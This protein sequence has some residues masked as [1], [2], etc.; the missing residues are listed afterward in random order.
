MNK[1]KK[2]MP[3]LM[4][5]A[6]LL[7][8]DSQPVSLSVGALTC[9]YAVQPLGI[10]SGKPSLGWQIHSDARNVMQASFRVL[11]SDN[12]E[13]LA[14]DEG[15]CWDSGKIRSDVSIQ[16]F[17]DGLPLRPGATYFWKVKIW[18]AKG[19][20]SPWS[21]MSSWQMGLPDKAAWGGAKWIALEELPA[22]KRI[23][24]GAENKLHEDLGK[25]E[26]LLPFLRKEFILQDKALK[27]ATAFVSGLGHFDM[28]I[29]GEKVG[30]HF[31][32]PGWTEYDHYALYL[33]FDILP[34]LRNGANACGL[35]LGNG[36]FHTPHERYLK[37]VVSY[38]YPKAICKLQIEYEDGTTEEII[39]DT[40]WKAAPSPVTFSS[41]Y[42]GED[43]D[44]RLEQT[45]WNMPGFDDS[46]WQQALTVSGTELRSQS[47]TPVE[48]TDTIP[49][50]R[51]FQSKGRWIYDL[52]QNFSGIINLSVDAAAG[53]SL[54]VWPGELLD[55]DSLVTQQASGSPFWFGYTSSGKKNEEWRPQFTYYG[56]RY[57]MLDGAVPQGCDN[58][59]KL[60]VVTR[61][62]GLH[63]R[64]AAPR[65]GTFTCSNDLF[66][67]IYRLIDWSIRSNMMSVMTDC[68]HRE[69]LGW[70]EEVHLMG[71]SVQYNYNIKRLYHKIVNDIRTAQLPDGLVPDIVPE[72]VVFGGGFRDS[73]EWGSSA[74]IVPW[75]LYQWYGDRR[76][77]QENYECMKRYTAYLSTKADGHILPY[78]LG[79]WFDIGPRSPGSSQQTSNGV[80]ATAIYYYDVCIMQKTAALLGYS[81]DEA[82][83]RQLA[84]EIREA[85]N[86]TFF[87][88][89]TNNYDNGSQTAN[90]MA[91]YMNLVEP[92]R[93]QAVFDNILRDLKARDYSQ[94]PGDIGFRYFLRVLESE[95][96]SED[97]FTIN[98]REDVPGYGFQLA[99]G[100]TALTESWAALRYVSNNHC[101]LGHLMEWFYS[102]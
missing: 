102:G 62:N 13:T 16:T 98:N 38:G 51:M 28:S 49:P 4:A 85:F 82:A 58:P 46:R 89:E 42:G 93:R 27:K 67:R 11:V 7:A 68:P 54:K 90:A 10:E 61:I 52:G 70:L 48:I 36:F 35:H 23:V 37:C 9:E 14:K 64:N 29:N 12:P 87:H 76:P 74:V 73:P 86:K 88:P 44:A 30:N 26:D 56:F 66:N 3:A 34:Y 92:Q 91:L 69:K 24:A 6:S 80:T 45:G 22:E 53:Q 43:Y 59:N 19:H 39:S 94:T 75:Y 79:D 60:P 8:C 63:V 77:L 25:M 84:V 20:E 50:V 2:V 72:Y 65:S 100:A 5:L 33:T 97:I 78:G 101:M 55:D 47:S 96:A 17:Y 32:D 57:L 83:Y 21:E 71:S 81:D 99:H 15:N 31:M 1:F 95:G 40:S 18:D 41:I